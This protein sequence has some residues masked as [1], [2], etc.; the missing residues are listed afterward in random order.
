MS[1]IPE[2]ESSADFRKK[3]GSIVSLM[4]LWMK[5]GILSNLVQLYD[6]VYRCFT[7]PD[8]QLMPTLEDYSYLLG[9]HITDRVPFTGLV[10]EPKSHEITTVIHLGKSEI[11][12]NM[13]TK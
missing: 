11:E 2:I 5:E 3:F 6:S 10:G 8:Y 9:L 4:N 13:T 12:A 7:F 1:L